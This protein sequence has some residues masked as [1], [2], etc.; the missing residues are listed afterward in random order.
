MCAP[1]DGRDPDGE[2][3]AKNHLKNKLWMLLDFAP[4]QSTE[5]ALR[6]AM[7]LFP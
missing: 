2:L 5:A 3:F 7:I 1:I 4:G 6:V